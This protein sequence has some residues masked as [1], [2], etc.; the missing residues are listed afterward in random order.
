MKKLKIIFTLILIL[1]FIFYIK[2]KSASLASL[3]SKA[4]VNS[5]IG[6]QKGIETIHPD[7]W[8][9]YVLVFLNIPAFIY[10]FFLNIFLYLIFKKK[11]N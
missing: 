2:F 10:M 11:F 8:Y 5:L 9:N 7:L 3:W 6:F 4:H 1:I